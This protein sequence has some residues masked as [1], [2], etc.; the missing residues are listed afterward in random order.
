M[1][2]AVE[3]IKWVSAI[4]QTAA[5][6]LVND[7]VCCHLGP[8]FFACDP[9][10]VGQNNAWSLFIE[11]RVPDLARPVLAGRVSVDGQ[12]GQ[13][14]GVDEDAL[15]NMQERVQIQVQQQCGHRLAYNA[16]G[17]ILPYQ[18]M[19]K[20]RVYVS[21]EIAF[22]AGAEDRPVL[23]NGTPPVWRV[24]TALRL[25]WRNLV[26]PL[27]PVDVNAVTGE[28]IPLAN[29]EIQSRRRQ[30]EYVASPAQLEAAPAS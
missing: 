1:Q 30:V 16:D 21:D 25:W 13:I 20:A 29:H 9:R 23:I 12:T 2:T 24:E 14:N 15:L 27:G 6:Q 3:P 26:L 18:A 22:F 5:E 28:V 11:C 8:N 10:W 19:I 7:F 17:L 4:D